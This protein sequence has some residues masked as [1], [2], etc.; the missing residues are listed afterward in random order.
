[1]EVRAADLDDAAVQELVRFHHAEMHAI[2]PSEHAFVFDIER[3]REPHLQ[4]LAAY[5]D[6]QLLGIG[7]VAITGD[8]AEIK[9][10][11]TAPEHIRRGVA[12][13]L[14]EGLGEVAR[15][16]G[17]RRLCLETGSGPG[18]E[19]AWQFYLRNGFEPCG[20]FGDY[21]ASDFNRFMTKPI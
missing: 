6:A 13:A 18:F 16:S 11:R 10:M 21:V 3:L 14:L 20:P 17:V 9:S 19:A 4:V 2:S 8:E 15:R 12:Q 5:D 7:A 1:M